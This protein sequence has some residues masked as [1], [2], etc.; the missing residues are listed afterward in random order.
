MCCL[1][2][3]KDSHRMTCSAEEAVLTLPLLD[4]PCASVLSTYV[5]MCAKGAIIGAKNRIYMI[6]APNSRFFIVTSPAGM[7][8]DT[9]CA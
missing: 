6:S 8:E 3:S 7:E 2:S 1:V 5:L 4:H 9:R